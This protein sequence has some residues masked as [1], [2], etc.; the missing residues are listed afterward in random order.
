M[1]SIL[2]DLPNITPIS[3]ETTTKN[4]SVTLVGNVFVYDGS[5]DILEVFWTKNGEKIHTEVSGGRLSTVTVDNPKL[6]IRDVSHIDAGEYKLTARNAVGETSSDI[7]VLGILVFVL[8]T[9]NWPFRFQD[10]KFKWAFLIKVY[11]IL[12]VVG[13]CAVFN[14]VC[15]VVDI[16]SILFSIK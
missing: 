11:P 1:V 3:V 10:P 12:A 13:A 8:N 15:V 5:P 4:N 7:I 9:I 16:F 2:I 14:G 6:T